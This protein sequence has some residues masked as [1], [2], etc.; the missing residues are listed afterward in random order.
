MDTYA[1]IDGNKVVNII[2]YENQPTTSIPGLD[3][4][5]IAVL[6]NGAGIGWIYE[7][8]VFTAPQPYPSWT[9]VDN[10]WTSPKSYPDDGKMYFWDEST[11]SWA[12]V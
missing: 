10:I 3:P 7:N 6:A 9:L 8:N 11:K 5:Y 4:N 2:D 1:I 12:N